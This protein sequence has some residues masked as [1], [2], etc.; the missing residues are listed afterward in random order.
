MLDSAFWNGTDGS[1]KIFY[2]DEEAA[3]YMTYLPPNGPRL[4]AYTNMHTNGSQ[5]WTESSGPFTGSTGSTTR[6]YSRDV[7]G[8]FPLLP[9]CP[10]GTD[11]CTK[12][13]T[14]YGAIETS[15]PS[16]TISVSYDSGTGMLTAVTS[17]KDL[18]SAHIET[19]DFDAFS[20]LRAQSRGSHTLRMELKLADTVLA[21]GISGFIICNDVDGDGY[22][23]TSEGGD[24]CDDLDRDINPDV[25]EK[26]D[27]IDNNCN[28][29]ADE[30]FFIG[31]KEMGSPCG[32]PKESACTGTWRCTENGSSATCFREYQPGELFEICDNGIDED[33]DGEIDEL[34]N[35]DGS[36][37][38]WCKP[39]ETKICGSNVGICREGIMI[40]SIAQSGFPEWS[41]CKDAINPGTER[42]NRLDDNCDGIVDNV[43]GGTSIESSG[44]G[45]YG[46]GKPSPE[47]CNDIDDNCDGQTDEGLP[48]CT[49]GETRECG[50]S[51][52]ACRPGTQ[53]CSGGSWQGSECVDGIGP[54]AEI[55]YNSLD[56]DC[57]SET[58]EGCDPEYTCR[59]G[60][61]DLNED[62][63]D[64]GG[65]CLRECAMGPIW[66]IAGGVMILVFLG[67]WALVMKKRL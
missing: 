52:G 15:D 9:D 36:P 54:S 44:C 62:G 66:M 14:A 55:C 28:G 41:V 26:C 6:S 27:S 39:G 45:C 57:D 18:T 1:I 59:N 31:G 21:S 16:G 33:C 58:D 65:P 17:S 56:D 12:A 47:T 24:D 30:G 42:C 19:V 40:C 51:V 8:L 25:P 22:C 67:I 53:T 48:C 2:Y 4:C 3:Y 35:L 32:G 11:D 49:D 10:P 50:L 34:M 60:I 13:V 5:Q 7:S 63:V 43:G 61:K 46:M 64:C 37:A 20:G 29:Q 23:N 38:C